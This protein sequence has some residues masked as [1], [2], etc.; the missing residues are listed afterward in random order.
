MAS[1][2]AN[3]TTG[4]TLMPRSRILQPGTPRTF[5]QYFEMPFTIEDILAEFDCTIIRQPINLPQSNLSFNLEPVTCHKGR[6]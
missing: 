3:Y 6:Y 4:V 1:G 2:R 5:S